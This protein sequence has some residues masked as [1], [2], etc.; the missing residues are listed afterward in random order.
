MKV[1]IQ[2]NI[3]RLV[4]RIIWC[5][6]VSLSYRLIRNQL[7]RNLKNK[8]VRKQCRK[9]IDPTDYA[10]NSNTWMSIAYFPYGCLTFRSSIDPSKPLN[11]ETRHLFKREDRVSL[12]QEMFRHSKGILKIRGSIWN[13]AKEKK[14][15][16]KRKT[17]HKRTVHKNQIK[18]YKKTTLVVMIGGK[19]MVTELFRDKHNRTNT[20]GLSSAPKICFNSVNFLIS[21]E[22]N[23]PLNI[24]EQCTRKSLSHYLERAGAAAKENL[25][26]HWAT[27]H[28]Y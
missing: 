17:R 15:K 5:R 18:R 2:K 22:P 23:V 12:S 10:E 19:A 6:L 21:L 27:Q 8:K 14:R 13:V 4:K 1:W 26:Q 9:V 25:L 3:L 20:K 24:K 11:S 7:Q 16:Q 28:L